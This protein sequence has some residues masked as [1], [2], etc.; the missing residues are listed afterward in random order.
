MATGTLNVKMRG[1]TLMEILIVVAIVGILAGIA[2]PSYQEQVAKAKRA[3]AAAALMTGAQALERYYTSNG[4]YL[5]ANDKLAAVFPTKAPE[6]GTAYYNIAATGTPTA[7]SYTLRATRTGSM[8]NDRC[9][10]LEI[11]STGARTLNGNK[12][13]TTVA[14]CW[15]R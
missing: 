11:S 14:D 2:Y 7:N 12:S 5:D 1:F 9:G 4:S 3:D 15:R 8:A 13:G 6:S 10:N